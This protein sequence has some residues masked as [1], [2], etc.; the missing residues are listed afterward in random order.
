MAS[1]ATRALGVFVAVTAGAQTYLTLAENR[2][3]R[4]EYYKMEET[5]TPE[6]RR[7]AR[8]YAYKNTTHTLDEDLVSLGLLYGGLYLA[9]SPQKKRE[10]Q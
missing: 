10:S 8:A 6:V 7:D 4:R 1:T 2:E 5:I 3:L 9:F